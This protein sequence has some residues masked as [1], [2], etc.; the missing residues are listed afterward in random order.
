M[1]LCAPCRHE[2]QLLG[3]SCPEQHFGDQ[4]VMV[5][6]IHR[7]LSVVHNGTRRRSDRLCAGADHDPVDAPK[8]FDAV[9]ERD[10]GRAP[11][12]P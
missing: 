7:R 10:V 1:P 8:Y 4:R 3:V 2:A 12:K 5:A 11:R 6:G 9:V